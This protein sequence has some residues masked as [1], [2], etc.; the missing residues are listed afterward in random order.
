MPL[1]LAQAA[2]HADAER[3]IRAF[4]LVIEAIGR[5]SAYL[6]LL[7][8]NPIAL[9]QL[10][11][12]CAASPWVSRHIG[13]HPV[14]LDELLHPI[15]DIRERGKSDLS[16]ELVERLTQ[17]EPGDEEGQLNALREFHQAQVLRIAAADV[18]GVLEV[19]DVHRSLTELAEV[20][21]Q[22]VF[23]DS[24][25]HVK[26]RNGEMP[27]HA[28][29]IAYGKFASAE[30]GYHSDL[31]VVVCY[32]PATG[33][34][35][36]SGH[37]QEYFY[38]RVGRR[39]IHLLTVRT[40]AGI[41][42]DLDMRLRP[43][44]RSGTLVTSLGGFFDYQMKDA[45]TWEHQALVRARPVVGSEDFVRE[46]ERM[47]GAVLGLKR[48]SVQLQSD[49]TTMR[50]KMIDANCQ[51]TSQLYD[52]KLDEG[53]IV[54]IEFLVQYLVLLHAADNSRL[55]SP[56]TTS[57]S[58]NALVEAGILDGEQGNRLLQCYRTY[59]RHSLDLKLLDR[60]VLV[61]QSI[62]QEEREAVTAIWTATFG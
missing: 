40:Q 26:S 50:R 32:L 22:Q 4:V 51:S 38:S 9:K 2:R 28:G 17:V 20:L 45:W 10:L 57:D 21:L 46:F 47:R 61:Q 11:H 36:G 3:A 59:L 7:I 44:G 23:D 39:L 25:E 18:S 54:D 56:R 8:E 34:G 35:N 33:G 49:I 27:G 29:I 5:R 24:V 16:E 13:Q 30:L 48:E 60:P 6:S 31:D 1:A 19:G 62:L 43:S 58:L 52:L 42:Y 37:E 53:G 55:I 41:L 14:I 12:L 15:V